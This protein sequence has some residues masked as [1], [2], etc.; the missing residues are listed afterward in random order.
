VAYAV[1]SYVVVCISDILCLWFRGRY[2]TNDGG[3]ELFVRYVD[4]GTWTWF[5]PLQNWSEQDIF[6]SRRSCTSGGGERFEIDR[7]HY[8]VSSVCSWKICTQVCKFG[9]L[10]ISLYIYVALWMCAYW[11]LCYFISVLCVK[12]F[13]VWF[14]VVS[15]IEVW[16]ILHIK[17]FCI[18]LRCCYWI[19]IVQM[20]IVFIFSFIQLNLE[21]EER[22]WLIECLCDC[23]A[24]HT[25]TALVHNCCFELVVA[26]AVC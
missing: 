9:V 3:G 17:S 4:R 25:K 8:P 15:D 22:W 16:N 24:S 10:F 26:N 23:C 2:C 1:C 6:P 13:K 18:R 14:L 11:L 7:H 21:A 20:I 12:V 19:C 5:Q